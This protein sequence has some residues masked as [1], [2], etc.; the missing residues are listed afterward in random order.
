M[1][2][3]CTYNFYVISKT[4]VKSIFVLYYTYLI[5][6]TEGMIFYL[7]TCARQR[8]DR[9]RDYLSNPNQFEMKIK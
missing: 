4:V 5:Q 8:T 1:Q 6:Y 9:M 7:Y 2:N 3:I